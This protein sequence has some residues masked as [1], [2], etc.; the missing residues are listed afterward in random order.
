MDAG[1]AGKNSHY[2]SDS[3]RHVEPIL[4][5]SRELL[6]VSP[7]IDDYYA[8]YLASRPSRKKTYVIS[9]SIRKSASRRLAAGRGKDAA[10]AVFVLAAV[11]ALMYQIGAFNALVLF[12]SLLFSVYC[13][14]FALT[15]RS[16][17]SLK[18]PRNFVH[19]KMYVG[20]GVAVEGS[21]NLTYAGMHKNVEEVRVFTDADE[22]EAMR[23]SFW[24]LWN[25]L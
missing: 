11:N 7:Y 13:V 24:S 8:S 5:K 20:D 15:H 3:Y 4:R 14:W 25:S 12:A 18:V 2:G 17:I 19:A 16:G 23:R 9:S 6:I 22:V 10:F 1:R 21:A